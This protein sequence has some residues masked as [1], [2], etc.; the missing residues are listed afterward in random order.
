MAVGR[1]LL[2]AGA[3]GSLV[4]TARAPAFQIVPA[5][6]EV[7]ALLNARCEPAAAHERLVQELLVRFAGLGEAEAQAR[8]RATSCPTCGCSLAGAVPAPPATEP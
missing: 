7:A 6:P 1:R 2:L 4:P 3:L 8:V 5:S